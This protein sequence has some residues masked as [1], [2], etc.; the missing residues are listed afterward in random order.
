M[1]YVV[2]EICIACTSEGGTIPR[3]VKIM[4]HLTCIQWHSQEGVHGVLEHP[5]PHI[6]SP[7]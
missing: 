7:R 4:I 1:V 3:S 6:E 2:Y 5:S